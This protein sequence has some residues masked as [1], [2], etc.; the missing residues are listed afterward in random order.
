MPIRKGVG[1]QKC[2]LTEQH[3]LKFRTFSLLLH[4]S[5]SYW[6]GNKKALKT[7]KLYVPKL[8]IALDSN[9]THAK[10]KLT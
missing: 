8:Y 1:N 5:C 10:A 7:P 6:Q 3:R 2:M 9:R 4:F